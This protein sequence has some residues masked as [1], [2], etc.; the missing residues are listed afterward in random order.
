[1][2]KKKKIIPLAIGTALILTIIPS[3]LGYAEESI[4]AML[5]GK[6]D[7][8][9]LNNQVKVEKA[10]KSISES[11]NTI[12]KNEKNNKKDLISKQDA[13]K[14]S[15][16]VLEDYFKAN[17]S[18][19]TPVKVEEKADGIFEITVD[20][21]GD[22]GGRYKVKI[23]KYGSIKSAYSPSKT[24]SVS[25]NSSINVNES[26]KLINEFL[27]KYEADK[28]NDINI[29]LTKNN[30][31]N[32][33]NFKLQRLH[34]NIEVVEEGGSISVDSEDMKLLSFDISWSN[35]IFEEEV[36]KKINKKEAVNI[37]R[38]SDAILPLYV[39]YGNKYILDFKLSTDEEY[40]IDVNKRAIKDIFKDAYTVKENI[41]S[42]IKNLTNTPK[43][44]KE[45]ESVS[46]DI[47]KRLTGKDGRALPIKVINENG[48]NLI[49]SI[50]AT[51]SGERYYV[52]YDA[53]S[54]EVLNIYKYGYETV[55]R[56][57]FKPIEF[58]D[59]Y[60]KAITAMALIYN[61]ELKNIN[62]NQNEYEL[63]DSRVYSFNFN[64][65]YNDIDVKDQY[66][67]VNVDAI[68]GEILSVFIEWNKN[69]K[70]DDANKKTVENKREKYLE[71]LEG[72]HVYI[73]ENGR[74]KLYYV[75]KNK[76]Y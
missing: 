48:T 4:G 34:N 62:L 43:T 19:D 26:K 71:S 39:G 74:G 18:N 76:S 68:T 31:N 52:E 70:F 58:K 50:I 56:G 8:T 24:E 40:I 63:S 73:N 46:L 6:Q 37:L 10:K 72:E 44:K 9:Q 28:I 3:S 60:K 32:I 59:A 69:S 49:R 41:S 11:A 7:Y 64:R 17:I 35:A 30:H 36:G 66:I 42:G 5:R 33:L 53:K 12:F 25:K 29:I 21:N 14:I 27:K 1:M 75:L 22:K 38:K 23:D 54:F 47:I 61:K 55:E 13:E 15:R 2:S 65:V 45:V 57:N 16:E 20:V 51:K 67:S